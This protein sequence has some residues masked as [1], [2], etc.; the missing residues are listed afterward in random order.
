MP[1]TFLF[2]RTGSAFGLELC[3]ETR[4]AGQGASKD[5]PASA[6][7]S[8]Q[9]SEVSSFQSR[10]AFSLWILGT[11]S[12]PQAQVLT[13][14]RHV[15]TA[16]VVS[17]AQACLLC[18]GSPSRFSQRNTSCSEWHSFMAVCVCEHSKDVVNWRANV[19]LHIYSK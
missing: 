9:T 14:V 8:H 5:G 19:H 13:V 6:S 18:R 2:Y 7:L 16:S 17:P 3:Q 10:S 12:E 1:S 15:C 11:D 4:L